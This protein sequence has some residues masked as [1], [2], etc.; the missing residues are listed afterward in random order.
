MSPIVAGCVVCA[1][2]VRPGPVAIAISEDTA[3]DRGRLR[4]AFCR[5]MVRAAPAIDATS[6][7]CAAWCAAGAVPIIADRSQARP[8]MPIAQARAL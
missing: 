8:S 4:G 3:R 6:R 5:R 7:R 1:I 2:V